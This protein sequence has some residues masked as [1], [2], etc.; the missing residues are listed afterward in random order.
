MLVFWLFQSWLVP[1][2]MARRQ[3]QD[4]IALWCARLIPGLGLV[5]YFLRRP[6][7]T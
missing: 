1:D 3:W 5:I 2:D 6:P 7:M 4:P